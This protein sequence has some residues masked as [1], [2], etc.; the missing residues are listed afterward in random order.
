[1]L[2]RTAIFAT[3]CCNAALG[4]ASAEVLS[5]GF[6]DFGP[7]LVCSSSELNADVEL[8]EEDNYFGIELTGPNL[9]DAEMTCM[10]ADGQTFIFAA[11]RYTDPQANYVSISVSR[12]GTGQVFS[13]GMHETG[14][15]V[16]K[17]THTL[18]DALRWIM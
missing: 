3:W 15:V 13:T 5:V 10:L 1:M 16:T 2:F 18:K 7:G 9:S 11:G 4:S 8:V 17:L 12:D 14:K 6:S